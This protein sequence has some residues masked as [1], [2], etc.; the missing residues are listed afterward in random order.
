M[1]PAFNNPA[2]VEN[3]DDVG[4][5][6]RAETVRDGDSRASPGGCVQSSLHHLLG[7]GV[8]SG[9]GFVEQEDPRVAEKSTSNSYTLFLPS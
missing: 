8:Q 1:R 4:L 3:I 5:L 7:L 2:L 6:D 9:S